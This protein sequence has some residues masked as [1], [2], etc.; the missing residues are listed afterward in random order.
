[1]QVIF[2]TVISQDFYLVDFN[3]KYL[4][5]K[6]FFSFAICAFFFIGSSCTKN[7]IGTSDPLIG[8]WGVSS[9]INDNSDLTGRFDGYTF[10]CFQDGTLIISG[11][12]NTY[13]CTWNWND[14]DHTTCHIEIEG[15]CD[16]QSV[17]WECNNDWEITSCDQQFCH[18]SSQHS[19]HH[20][21][22]V[23]TKL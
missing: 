2:L 11:N 9:F 12:G 23:W 18:F 20:N 5:M 4:H 1:M 15:S 7:E 16:H 6:L 21:E 19:E 3:L 17:L 13:N 8:T 14:A 22:M 10:K